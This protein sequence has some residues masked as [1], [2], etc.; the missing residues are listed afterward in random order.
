[1]ELSVAVTLKRRATSKNENDPKHRNNLKITM[2]LKRKM[3]QN[4][5]KDSLRK[6]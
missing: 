3:T 1:M 2:T 5:E 4:T 6:L